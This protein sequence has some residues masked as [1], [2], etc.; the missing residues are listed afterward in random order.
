MT[1]G[2]GGGGSQLS[3]Q[4]SRGGCGCFRVA[5]GVLARGFRS[6]PAP[7]GWTVSSGWGGVGFRL[8]SQPIPGGVACELEL[9]GWWLA[10]SS[11]AQPQGRGQ[12][13]GAEGM[14]DCSSPSSLTTS[15]PRGLSG[16]RSCS[17]NACGPAA[18]HCPAPPPPAAGQAA[19][20]AASP[21]PAHGQPAGY[22]AHRPCGCR[23]RSDNTCHP[24]TCHKK[25]PRTQCRWGSATN[26]GR[27]KR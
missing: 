11:A 10:F 9:G 23:R 12:R 7:G 24:A 3:P 26:D 2:W 16:G 18:L 17:A 1:C 15:P 25:E 13:V 4:R 6:S 21:T 19:A 5:G 20:E 27:Q 14:L 8:S 22:R